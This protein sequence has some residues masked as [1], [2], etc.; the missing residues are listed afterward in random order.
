MLTF[1]PHFPLHELRCKCGCTPEPEVLA[2]LHRLSYALERLRK[3]VGQP[4]TVISGH[5]CP[6]H[7]D[8]V[9]GASRSRHLVGDA[10][11]IKVRGWTGDQLRSR[12]EGLISC[13]ELPE[14]GMGTYARTPA[15]L[16][17]DLRGERARWR[18]P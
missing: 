12:V 15:T 11:D 17:Y 14:G 5:R 13:G 10:A 1:A 4:I 9:G 8:A 6:S 18:N 2:N 16:H 7:N 3:D